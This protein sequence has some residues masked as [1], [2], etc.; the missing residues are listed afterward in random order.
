MHLGHGGSH[1]QAGENA[2]ASARECGMRGT[3]GGPAAAMFAL[4]SQNGVLTDIIPLPDLRP[5]LPAHSP[6]YQLTALA[7]PPDA[8]PPRA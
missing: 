5:A 2:P 4:L 8:L 3:C 1:E 7:A 6:S